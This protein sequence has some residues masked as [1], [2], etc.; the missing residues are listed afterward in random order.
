[1][2]RRELAPT[3]SQAQE[4]I[5]LGQVLV[6]GAVATKAARLVNPGDPIVLTG[7]GPRFVSRGGD[8]LDA[9]LTRFGIEPQ[10]KRVVVRGA[11]SGGF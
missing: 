1:M 7:A 5:D 4:L 8:K 11:S 6:G 10:G 2:I 9:A 3:R